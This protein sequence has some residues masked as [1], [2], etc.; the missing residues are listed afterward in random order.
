MLGRSQVATQ[1]VKRH[2]VK[3]QAFAADSI[4]ALFLLY[5]I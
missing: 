3:P 1:R 5:A 4:D 2:N